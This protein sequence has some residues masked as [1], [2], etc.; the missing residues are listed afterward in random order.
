VRHLASFLAGAVFAVGLVVGG[1]TQPRKVIAF[2]DVSGGAWDPSLAFVMVGGVLVYAVGLPAVR[3]RPAPVFGGRF[4]I[5]S[6][7][8][9]APRLFVGAALF[10]AGWALAGFCPGPAVVAAGARVPETMLF[11]PSMLVGMVLFHRWDAWSVDRARNNVKG[12]AP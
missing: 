5:P 9:L 1:M 2:L 12:T 4:Q 8:D 10:G 6:R 3:R 7:T 11:I